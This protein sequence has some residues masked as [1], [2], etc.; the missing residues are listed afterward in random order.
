MVIFR[1]YVNLPEGIDDY[2]SYADQSLL[3]MLVIHS[4]HLLPK[5]S[6]WGWL[7]SLFI[8]QPAPFFVDTPTASFSGELFST[9]REERFL[10]VIKRGLLEDL[11]NIYISGNI[12][13]K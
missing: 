13:Y 8:R 4:Q 10:Q 9:L 11:T 2:D 7:S 3:K 1:V 12:T 6:S 5:G